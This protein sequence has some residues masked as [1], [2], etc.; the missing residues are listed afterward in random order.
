MCDTNGG[1]VGIC[2]RDLRGRAIVQCGKP[3]A[4]LNYTYHMYVSVWR[5]CCTGIIYTTYPPGKKAV[6]TA[7]VEQ[8]ES[9][10]IEQ[11]E[12]TRCVFVAT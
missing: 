2:R 4:L 9:S 3:D 11:A 8:A 12:I 1:V 10:I 7:V 5:Y 6:Q